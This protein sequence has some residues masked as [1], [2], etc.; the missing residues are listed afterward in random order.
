MSRKFYFWEERHPDQI[1]RMGDDAPVTM[2]VKG[3]VSEL[4]K[5]VKLVEEAIYWANEDGAKDGFSE[6]G[7]DDIHVE[8][9]AYPDGRKIK[10]DPPAYNPFDE[11][12]V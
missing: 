9:Y 7:V 11:W 2:V 12:E 6:D 5:L 1:L 4:R 3:N 8:I 10:P